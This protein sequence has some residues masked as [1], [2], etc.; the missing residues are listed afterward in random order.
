MTG[1]LLKVRE[2]HTSVIYEKM[3]I[4]MMLFRDRSLTT[5]MWGAKW[6]RECKSNFTSTKWGLGGG[7]SIMLKRGVRNGSDFGLLPIS[8]P[9]PLPLIN[10]RSLTEFFEILIRI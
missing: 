6:E 9:P 4:L 5:E 7:G 2:T 10:D 8:Y 3:T 1:V